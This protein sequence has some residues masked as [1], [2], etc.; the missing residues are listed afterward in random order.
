MIRTP[1]SAAIALALALAG[2]SNA[3]TPG[4][5]QS[6]KRGAE[7][8]NAGDPKTARIELMNAIKARPGDA[9]ARLL[10]AKVQI[11]L[12]DGV[13]AEAEIARARAS[14]VP[15][16]ATRTLMAEALLLQG[17]PAD[18]LA[19]AKAAPAA[20]AGDAARLAGKAQLAGGDMDAA[21][22]SF[23]RAAELT[24]ESAPLWVDIARY[25]RAVGDIGGA[26]GAADRALA[27]DPRADGALLVR[28]ELTRTQYGLK[29]ALPWFDR[30]LEAKPDDATVL[31]EKAATLGEMGAMREML[32]ATRAALKASPGHPM[33][34]YLQ[35]VLAARGGNYA[36]ARAIY[37]KSGGALAA[38]P[39]PALFGAALDYQAG[40]FEAASD[41]LAKLLA[42]QPDNL[43]ARRLLAASEWRAGE[44]AD[45]LAAIRPI[46]DREDADSYALA[47]AGEAAAKLG[48][49]AEAADYRARAARPLRWDGVIA[50]IGGDAGAVNGDVAAIREALSRADSAYA[51]A[52]ARQLARDNPGAP[53]AWL[54]VGDVL[55]L[56]DDPAAAVDP[57]RTAA[58]IA[59]T[60]PVALRLIEALDRS[61]QDAAA[62]ET[63]R[64]FLDQNPR[65][66]PALLIA[67]ERYAGAGEWANAEA[68]YHAVRRR[69]GTRDAALS[70]NL[71][72]AYARQGDHAA[73]LPIARRAWEVDRGNRQSMDAY[74]WMLFKTGRKAEGLA[75]MLASVAP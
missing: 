59:F 51:F 68:A 23:D 55:M 14:G 35:A 19:E 45:A 69:I 53:D 70:G 60:E 57:Y 40:N 12:G 22:A 66:I 58:N 15:A 49:A 30:A 38:E 6:L 29:A 21:G 47:L 54:L 64:L 61:G 37:A 67:A 36:L 44:M 73:A 74:G 27:L 63:L 39:G 5:D 20:H 52:L 18:A 3:S 34:F 4:F 75:L 1:P 41:T 24:P 43:R 46:A 10:Q 13:A 56:A 33:A 26:I 8:F 32:A 9:R 25:R 62:T 48:R 71:A 16:D 17:R 72:W 65:S 28:G 42:D 11:A 31:L 7:A 2:C 50:P